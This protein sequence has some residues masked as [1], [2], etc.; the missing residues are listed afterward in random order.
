MG[1]VK[2]TTKVAA[3]EKPS[4]QLEEFQGF[5][6]L[7][8][9][10]DTT[11]NARHY[12]Y[13]KK[14]ESKALVDEDIKDR[15]LFLLNL[16]ADTTDRH[17]KKLF[18]GHGID[19]IT[20]HDAGSSYAEEYWKIAANVEAP[21][22]ETKT[23]KNKKK[24]VQKEE[25]REVKVRELRRLFTSGSSAHVV[26][27]TEEDLIEVLNMHR[28]EKKWAKEDESEQPL[29]FERYVLAY[30]LSR[31]SPIEL[32]QEVDTFM[33]KFKADEY[34]K[35]REKLERM[36]QMDD[37][38]FTVVVRHKKTK[39]TDGTI[40]VGAI[41][42]EAAEAQRVNQLKKKKELVN[43]YRFQMREKKQDEL[44]ELRK[45]FEEDKAKIAQLKQTRKFKPY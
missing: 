43:F 2:K 31:P 41:T 30:D 38:G 3:E 4:K 6:V 42:T 45:R 28:V 9:V 37:D 7:P 18:K 34:Q 1:K 22:L 21:E 24:N 14:H 39:A 10:V 5:K 15:T 23:K 19:K 16:P 12:F 33:M 25:E 13:L 20:Y 27:T 29:G 17:I 32:Q 35:E 36:N 8:V 44:V 40:H 26:F 11:K